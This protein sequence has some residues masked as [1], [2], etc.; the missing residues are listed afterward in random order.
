MFSAL[1]DYNCALILTLSLSHL[2]WKPNEFG[3]LRHFFKQRPADVAEIR[4]RVGNEID[5]LH[6]CI[7]ARTKTTTAPDIYRQPTTSGT[8]NEAQRKEWMSA[9]VNPEL[10]VN[11]LTTV[12]HFTKIEALLKYLWEFNVPYTKALWLIKVLFN[13]ARSGTQKDDFSQG[14]ADTIRQI[15]P[16]L[17]SRIT[18]TNS[19]QQHGSSST[20]NAFST[21][22]YSNHFS[23]SNN[24]HSQASNSTSGLQTPSKDTSHLSLSSSTAALASPSTQ[25]QFP[26]LVNAADAGLTPEQVTAKTSLLYIIRLL[27][28]AYRDGFIPLGTLVD[29]FCNDFASCSDAC[30]C[31]YLSILFQFLPDIIV[32]YPALERFKTI[33]SNV[34]ERFADKFPTTLPGSSS[35]GIHHPTPSSHLQNATSTPSGANTPAPPSNSG[36]RPRLFSLYCS[37]LKVLVAYLPDFFD[38]QT[39]DM[40]RGY[41]ASAYMDSAGHNSDF[42]S[43]SSEPESPSL[44]LSTNFPYSAMAPNKSPSQFSI[45]NR[46]NC[47]GSTSGLMFASI[48]PY[49]LNP[50]QLGAFHMLQ[51]NINANRIPLIIDSVCYDH[52]CTLI[53]NSS[54]EGAA[55]DSPIGPIGR[56]SPSSHTM[57]ALNALDSFSRHLDLEQLY[58]ALFYTCPT[59]FCNS[60]SA[61][62]TG[63]ASGF[64]LTP[65]GREPQSPSRDTGNSVLVAGEALE[66]TFQLIC[67]WVVAPFRTGVHRAFVASSLIHR[68]LVAI[69]YAIELVCDLLID[70]MDSLPCPK[71]ADSCGDDVLRVASL[72]GELI[73]NRAFSH[74]KYLRRL[75]SRGVLLQVNAENPSAIKHKAYLLNIPLYGDCKY[76]RLQRSLTIQRYLSS[77]SEA[78]DLQAGIEHVNNC[79]LRRSIHEKDGND[80]KMVDVELASAEK[81]LFHYLNTVTL[82]CRCAT[83][84]YAI[85]A[86]KYLLTQYYAPAVA[87]LNTSVSSS[88]MTSSGFTAQN[89]SS[90]TKN[91]PLAK[92]NSLLGTTAPDHIPPHGFDVTLSLG[93]IGP[94]ADVILVQRLCVLLEHLADFRSVIDFGRWLLDRVLRWDLGNHDLVSRFLVPMFQAYEHVALAL[95][96]PM[97]PFLERFLI[98]AQR[99]ARPSSTSTATAAH[100]T[101]LPHNTAAAFL[102]KFVEKNSS[103][104]STVGLWAAEKGLSLEA[105]KR[106]ITPNTTPSK[107]S[108]K[109]LSSHSSASASP[110][111][112]A[113][114][115]FVS[116]LKFAENSALL[117]VTPNMSKLII[118]QVKDAQELLELTTEAWYARMASVTQSDASKSIPLETIS[119]ACGSPNTLQMALSQCFIAMR[120]SLVRNALS[121]VICG[122]KIRDILKAGGTTAERLL[123]HWIDSLCTWLHLSGN[124]ILGLVAKFIKFTVVGFST[125]LDQSYFSFVLMLMATL[126]H[127]SAN[128]ID[129]NEKRNFYTP[130]R[131]LHS[132]G[133]P[134][135]KK[136]LQIFVSFCGLLAAYEDR[137]NLLAQSGFSHTPSSLSAVKTETASQNGDDISTSATHSGSSMAKGP[138]AN[139]LMWFLGESLLSLPHDDMSEI[140]R[141]LGDSQRAFQVCSLIFANAKSPA[142][143]PTKGGIL[144]FASASSK[145]KMETLSHSESKMQMDAS[146]SESRSAWDA[147]TEAI[148]LKDV[149]QVEARVNA[150][151]SNTHIWSVRFT[152]LQLQ[153]LLD[154]ANEVE[155]QR[156]ASMGATTP[157]ASSPKRVNEIFASALM[158]RLSRNILCCD[159]FESASN[160]STTASGG[161]KMD[162]SDAKTCPISTDGDESPCS[163][164]SAQDKLFCEDPLCNSSEATVSLLRRLG[165]GVR[166]DLLTYLFG[167]IDPSKHQTASRN[168]L[169]HALLGKGME[170]PSGASESGSQS[171]DLARLSAARV[172]RKLIDLLLAI[173]SCCIQDGSSSGP[174]PTGVSLH[175]GSSTPVPPAASAIPVFPIDQVL[176]PHLNYIEEHVMPHLN[177]FSKWRTIR[178]QM[179]IRLSLIRWTVPSDTIDLA[180]AAA[181][182]SAMSGGGGSG[183]GVGG[184][185]GSMASS[186]TSGSSSASAAIGNAGGGQGSAGGLN[187]GSNRLGSDSGSSAASIATI[188]DKLT[189]LLLRLLA[190][191][192]LQESVFDG[193]DLW[194]LA[195]HAFAAL[196]NC[197]N[198][199][200]TRRAINELYPALTM[201]SHLRIRLEA[202]IQSAARK[203]RPAY[204]INGSRMLL[205]KGIDPSRQLEEQPDTN[206]LN[207]FG[208]RKVQPRQLTYANHLL[209]AQSGSLSFSS[210]H[211]A[212]NTPH[213]SSNQHHHQSQHHSSGS[214]Y[215]SH[216]SSAH[217][218]NPSKMA[219]QP[220][221]SHHGQQSHAHHPQSHHHSQQPHQNM[222]SYQSSQT[223]NY[224]S[225]NAQNAQHTVKLD[226]PTQ[227][228][229]RPGDYDHPSRAPPPQPR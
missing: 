165:A 111:S 124:L 115:T 22:S 96:F 164:W 173:A 147:F 108:I 156:N 223:A 92:A 17:F 162:E 209:S 66:R 199:T 154:A 122:N 14:I 2:I 202:V 161:S 133:R 19:A 40:I 171:S 28:W 43:L 84:Q 10:R 217:H 87:N 138:S 155:R 166:L 224:H 116:N 212:A 179:Y 46:L 29:R 32:N 211:S 198:Q 41:I 225:S 36:A 56:N 139:S 106:S 21:N 24:A 118:T 128:T 37:T 145:V 185:T 169:S 178:T 73:R 157:N 38:P 39:L 94:N 218:V 105:L 20:S 9:F 82:F 201:P 57:S 83:G 85:S 26:K 189:I 11:T 64:K 135:K 186:A 30:A 129:G 142:M 25:I 113:I 119:G 126:A 213:S 174:S 181:V 127:Y 58:N 65:N 160:D 5:V 23:T 69:P 143:P 77:T 210:S 13:S 151:L 140:F 182:G 91:D 97:G 4:S 132:L 33:L 150:I 188:L 193:K 197:H 48:N 81:A 190:S 7:Q 45:S 216:S 42:P 34:A 136:V 177:N 86:I 123:V 6:W 167:L 110:Q 79:L 55:T 44:P 76:D 60:S 70:F 47:L 141:S 8:M 88:S 200:S 75:I 27:G 62:N 90:T 121:G 183:S 74:D 95:D 194:T 175:Q 50:S 101:L 99:C 35:H 152:S 49:H 12:P 67:S 93:D 215:S 53:M 112:A 68:Y 109:L 1:Y 54:F 100:S 52:V 195:L 120:P 98:L 180:S 227:R 221:S 207:A 219:Q 16:V 114:S 192:A 228:V 3:N 187:Q 170:S 80:R 61:S 78:E 15:A 163:Q 59:G 158:Q 205:P 222:Q 107:P 72:I 104:V 148:D 208:A 131:W 31:L 89:N 102:C 134:I 63:S 103:K 146:S 149:A 204:L 125:Q 214:S 226:P 159:G 206:L 144:S 229:K 18:A 153:L 51:Q 71:D 117:S 196:K 184:G 172:E 176:E 220:S 191:P 203:D 137:D 168:F 130:A